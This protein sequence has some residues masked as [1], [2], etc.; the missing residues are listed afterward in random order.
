[1]SGDVQRGREIAVKV[2]PKYKYPA[3]KKRKAWDQ[4]E[5]ITRL[6]TAKE[7]DEIG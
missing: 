1:M 7:D 4:D 2:I 6:M 3:H 5:S